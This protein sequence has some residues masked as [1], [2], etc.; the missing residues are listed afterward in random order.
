VGSTSSSFTEIAVYNSSLS[1]KGN[2]GYYNSSD[3]MFVEAVTGDVALSPGGTTKLT[4][5]ASGNVGI[6][7]TNP[8]Y[9]L[10]VRGTIQSSGTA[11][12]AGM[13]QLSEQNTNGNN[14]I[15]FKAA[16]ALST[17]TTF[18]WPTNGGSLNQVLTTDGAGNLSW[19]TASGGSVTA[20][21]ISDAGGWLNG[22]NKFGGSASLGTTD[23]YSLAF[24]VNNTTAM[25][26]SQSGN[27]G[28]GTT[29]PGTAL[30]VSG[31][32]KAVD[33][34][35]VSDRRLKENVRTLPG[36]ELVSKMRGVSYNWISNGKADFGVIAQEME[37]V[38]PE[39]VFTDAN[40]GFKGVKYPNL[41]GPLIESTKELY[42][43]CKDNR[44]LGEQNSR[45]I[46]NVESRTSELEA[47]NKALAKENQE[48]K[49]R[50]DAIERK[51][52]I[53]K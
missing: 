36:L 14:F 22:G 44:V 29:S 8:S 47:K 21:A 49:A 24:K 41:V 40:T 7:A 50:L 20:Q 32:V 48:L 52:G 23:N 35:S 19:S 45:R 4:A 46:A 6:G 2:W 18:V 53:K 9:P 16:A 12:S 27:V 3:T 34:I 1:K 37:Q 30:E 5:K 42:G 28:I 15:A 26:I 33:F 31:D 11:A 43:M 51:L 13:I 17:D 10:D 38:L 39:A 25:S